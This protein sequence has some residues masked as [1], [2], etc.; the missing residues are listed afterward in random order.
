MNDM[1]IS[2]DDPYERKRVAVLDTEMTY[3]DVGTGDPIIFLH[4]N[5][6]SSYLWRNVLPPLSGLGRCLAPDLVGMGVSGKSSR[7]E[8]RAWPEESVPHIEST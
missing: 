6:T 7:W 4:G 8:Y 3:V 5:L 2:A 1:T